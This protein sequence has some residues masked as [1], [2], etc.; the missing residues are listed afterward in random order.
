MNQQPTPN[1]DRQRLIRQ[2]AHD[3]R[4]NLH[5]INMGL[6]TLKGA[7]NDA[8]MF[9]EIVTAIRHDGVQPIQA[10]LEALIELAIEGEQGD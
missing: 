2:L 7:R 4:S 3:V 10:H 9:A 1:D 6:E 8:D 5:V